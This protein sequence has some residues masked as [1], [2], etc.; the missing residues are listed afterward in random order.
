[1]SFMTLLVRTLRVTAAVKQA[2][3]PELLARLDGITLFHP[4][5]GE[6][7]RAV[8]R[9]ELE[10]LAARCRAQGLE[11]VWD[12]GAED[13]LLKSCGDAALGARPLRQ[14]VETQVEDPLAAALLAGKTGQQARLM[15][16]GGEIRVLWQAPAAV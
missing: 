7:L 15:A 2:F 5:D 9:Q 10:R 14:A 12:S 16:E 4:L 8:L 3:R 13:V 6:S 1:M 11:L